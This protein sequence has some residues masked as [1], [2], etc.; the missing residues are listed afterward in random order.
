MVTKKTF[1]NQSCFYT[2]QKVAEFD[3]SFTSTP[4]ACLIEPF[5]CQSN[6][7]I[8]SHT[9]FSSPNVEEHVVPSK[10]YSNPDHGSREMDGKYVSDFKI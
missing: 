7:F 3:H 5:S 6:N 1:S 8:Q 9:H 10:K 4:L 2:S